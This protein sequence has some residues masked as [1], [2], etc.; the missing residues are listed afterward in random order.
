MQECSPLLSCF[1]LRLEGTYRRRGP[2]IAKRPSH[3]SWEKGTN[4]KSSMDNLLINKES[5]LDLLP[6]LQSLFPWIRRREVVSWVIH[7]VMPE[8]VGSGHSSVPASLAVIW[9]L[10]FACL[11]NTENLFL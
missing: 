2:G 5:F 7:K 11:P 9:A 8:P 4:T 1:Y 3:L 10:D 6:V